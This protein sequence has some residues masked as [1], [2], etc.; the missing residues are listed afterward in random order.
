MLNNFNL[1]TVA[2]ILGIGAMTFSIGG[3]SA[4]AMSPISGTASEQKTV[5]SDATIQVA[6][7]NN[8]RKDRRMRTSWSR[9]RDGNRCSRRN[10]NC[11]YFRN[12]YYSENAWWTLPLI[13][14]RTIGAFNNSND[15]RYGNRHVG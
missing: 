4:A 12:G 6:P 5:A 13:I 15:G 3:A 11:R 7:M 2:T 1:L 9:N 8:N 10:G 14:G